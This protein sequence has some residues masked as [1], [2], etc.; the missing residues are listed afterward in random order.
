[1]STTKDKAH[2]PQRRAGLKA[3]G[4][5]LVA[6]AALGMGGKESQAAAASPALTAGRGWIEALNN[7][8]V[9][10]LAA[11]LTDD[12]QYSAMVKNPKEMIARW[13][14]SVFLKMAGGGGQRM[15]KPVIMTV[16]SELGAGDRAVIETEGYGEHRDGYVYNNVY[17][18]LFWTKGGKIS[19]IHDYCC[20]HTAVLN[21]Q[22]SREE[23]AAEAAKS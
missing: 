12:F 8:N 23:A 14:K 5:G 10:A 20:T 1:M 7:R 19:A 2:N 3:A 16:K 22:H 21:G 18:F 17:C 4:G 11:L 13:D 6:A 9:P 15:K